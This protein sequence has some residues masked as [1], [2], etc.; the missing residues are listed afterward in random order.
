MILKSES[1]SLDLGFP[2]I[3][4]LLFEIKKKVKTLKYSN[5]LHIFAQIFKNRG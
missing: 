4:I 2:L 3:F 5:Y 1:I